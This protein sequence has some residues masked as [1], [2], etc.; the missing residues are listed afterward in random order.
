MQHLALW[1]QSHGPKILF[2]T[3]PL[4]AALHLW[5]FDYFSHTLLHMF[6]IISLSLYQLPAQMGSLLGSS[7]AL[8]YLDCV[9]DESALLRLNFWLGYALHEGKEGGGRS[10][11]QSAVTSSVRKIQPTQ[12]LWVEP[13]HVVT[14][15]AYQ[16]DSSERGL[17]DW[18]GRVSLCEKCSTSELFCCFL[19]ILL[20][21]STH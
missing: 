2:F 15:L 11:Y 10:S 17:K 12:R 8:Q 13:E 6:P 3:S 1:I 21:F 20:T 14:H 5:I 7:L 9:Q 19:F 18:G 16:R 4:C